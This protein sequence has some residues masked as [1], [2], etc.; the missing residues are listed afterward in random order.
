MKAESK[1]ICCSVHSGIWYKGTHYLWQAPGKI[2]DKG[3]FHNLDGTIAL[4]EQA[5]LLTDQQFGNIHFSLFCLSKKLL[6]AETFK[7]LYSCAAHQMSLFAWQL[8]ANT[9]REKGKQERRAMFVCLKF[10][11]DNSNRA[12]INFLPQIWSKSDDDNIHVVLKDCRCRSG[13]EIALI[14]DKPWEQMPQ[15]FAAS[16]PAIIQFLLR[17]WWKGFWCS[18]VTHKNRPETWFGGVG[19]VGMEKLELIY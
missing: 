16:A 8:W 6:V 7:S 2:S 3:H 13:G 14:S 5:L 10:S 19:V 12:S 9:V 1:A 4:I 11:P 15:S 17:H 18:C